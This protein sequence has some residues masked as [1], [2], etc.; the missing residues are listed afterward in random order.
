MGPKN[1]L[2]SAFSSMQLEYDVEE[3]EKIGTPVTALTVDKGT[4]RVTN[5]VSV[6]S[7]NHWISNTNINT[8]LQLLKSLLLLKV[9]LPLYVPAF[10]LFVYNVIV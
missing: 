5:Y 10:H 7:T 1:S 3:N 4:S 6:Q 2:S 9:E 8:A